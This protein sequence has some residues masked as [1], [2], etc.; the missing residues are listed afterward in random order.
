MSKAPN[1]KEPADKPAPIPAMSEIELERKREIGNQV[2]AAV[3][4]ILTKGGSVSATQLAKWG[5]DGT[6]FFFR[7]LR[8][9]ITGQ[10]SKMSRPTSSSTSPKPARTRSR[11]AK[12][13]WSI[14]RPNARKR[15]VA[16]LPVATKRDWTDQQRH[17]W[18]T[19][20][21][22]IVHGLIVAIVL[23]A[24]AAVFMRLWATLASFIP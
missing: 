16:T 2:R 23:F 18:S 15:T 3:T 20:T 1:K 7:V 21:R 22:A 4:K 8:D 5:P 11:N 9:R 12:V 19:R 10:M 17:R 6:E 14:R 13:K 24:G